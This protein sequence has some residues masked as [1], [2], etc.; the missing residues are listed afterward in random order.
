MSTTTEL[1][2]RRAITM[3]TYSAPARIQALDFIKGALVLIMV[4]YHW[5]N[6]FVYNQ[7]PV[8]RYLRFLPPSFIC[9]SGFLVS[10]AYLSK[11]GNDR[12]SLSRRLA[13]R[14][15]KILGIF[16]VVNACINVMRSIGSTHRLALPVAPMD[17]VRIFVTG[18]VMS[19]GL[20][21]IAAF[22]ILVPIAYVL[23]LSAAIIAF[24]EM[25]KYVFCSACGLCVVAVASLRWWDVE[26]R[27]LEMVTVGLMGVVGGYWSREKIERVLGHRVLLGV[28]YS[29]YVG[30]ISVWD[31]FALQVA[32]VCLSLAALYVLG[33]GIANAGGVGRQVVLL[34]QYS[35]FAYL[36]QIAILRV[37]HKGLWS[38]SASPAV[39]AAAFVA[40]CAL[41]IAC[42]VLLDRARHAWATMNVV[43]KAVF[44]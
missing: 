10:H 25:H 8:L 12:F 33:G 23:L 20:E 2:A 11:Y 42:V 24:T 19:D 38:P 16:V 7:G 41:T 40:G 15:V 31:S 30:A 13:I 14:G 21:K 32:G 26:S 18:D 35:L 17:A 5:V 36:A 34:G 22:Y 43:Y 44:A 4:L 29:V 37:L 39:S 3:A 28:A 1:P 6:Y 9:I 27:N